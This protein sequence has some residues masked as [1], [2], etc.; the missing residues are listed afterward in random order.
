MR[1]RGRHH[2]HLRW[3][4]LGFALLETAVVILH[5]KVL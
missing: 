3:Y 4:L 2:K 5:G 1:I